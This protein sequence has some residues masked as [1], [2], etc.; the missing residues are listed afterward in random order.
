MPST[1]TT[2]IA[3]P[4]TGQTISYRNY[5]DGYYQ[6][7]SLISP[8]FVDNGDGTITD[9]VTNLMWQKDGY[10]WDSC[11]IQVAIDNCEALSLGGFTDWRLPNIKELMSIV[12]YGKNSPAIDQPP[13][14]NTQWGH[15]W[16]STYYLVVDFNDGLLINTGLYGYVRAVRGGI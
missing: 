8:R 9:R 10:Y 1:I 15:Y 5:D 4:K 7:G 3:L 14:T 11:G 12:N 16:S 2:K 6:K 13:F